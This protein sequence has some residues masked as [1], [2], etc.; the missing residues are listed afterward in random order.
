V[1]SRRRRYR[2]RPNKILVKRP[3]ANEGISA[4]N[5]RLVGA[6]GEQLG[7]VSKEEALR[8][9]QEAELD[10]VMV[11]QK[12]DPPVVRIMD[13]GKY[14]YEQKKKIAKQK[15]K[16]KSGEIK[17]LRISFK[18]SEHDRTMRLNQA[19][20]FLADGHKVKVEMRLRGREKGRVDMAKNML[21]AFIKEVPGGTEI[22]G[23]VGTAPNNISAVIARRRQQ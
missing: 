21:L 5:V 23:T 11:A 14:T 4:A 12:A 22:E 19:N 18:I 6:A 15:A 8:L 20:E 13:L 7:V 17:G 9:A 10:L 16:S 3:P 1:A 2:A